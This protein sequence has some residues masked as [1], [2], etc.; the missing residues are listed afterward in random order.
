MR[1]S[2]TLQSRLFQSGCE[3]EVEVLGR[4]RVAYTG[5][6]TRREAIA[7]VRNAPQAKRTDTIIAIEREFERQGLVVPFY[8]ATGSALDFHHGVDGFFE[9]RG[10]VVTIDVTM[11]P[12]KSVGKADVVIYPDDFKNIPV[13][14][15]RIG[16]EFITKMQKERR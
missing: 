13:L 10:E 15:A 8:P 14:A 6:L 3:F 12:E 11:N 2:N 16:R 5:Y 4:C 7:E 1:R 9:Y